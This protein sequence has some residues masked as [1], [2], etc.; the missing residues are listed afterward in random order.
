MTEPVVVLHL[1]EADTQEM[2]PGRMAAFAWA[3]GDT[4]LCDRV[5]DSLTEVRWRFQYAVELAWL[6]VGSIAPPHGQWAELGQPL[7]LRREGDITIISP[8][9]DGDTAWVLALA[10]AVADE[11]DT[12]ATR[13]YML[14][15]ND[16]D[17][18]EDALNRVLEMGGT[19]MRAAI[20]NLNDLPNST[21]STPSPE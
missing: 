10:T 1:S 19:E 13:L 20:G 6:A 3:T 4:N 14:R 17:R 11:D 21:S 9:V 2:G 8:G 15:E 16:P 12:E 5:R 18:L 7:G